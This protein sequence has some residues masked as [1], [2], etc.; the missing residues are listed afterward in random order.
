MVTLFC[1]PCM[2]TETT[3]SSCHTHHFVGNF[4][5]CCRTNASCYCNTRGKIVVFIGLAIFRRFAVG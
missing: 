2:L 1:A 5:S 3:T 4:M